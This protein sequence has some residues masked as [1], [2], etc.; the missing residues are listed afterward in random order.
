[1][2][3]PVGA[4]AIAMGE[5]FVAV[6]DDA[7]SLF[8]NPGGI[9]VA[10]APSVYTSHLFYFDQTSIDTLATTRPT[11]WGGV[12]AGTRWLTGPSLAK[13]KNN[14][15]IGEFTPLERTA[16][17]GL[18]LGKKQFGIGMTGRYY[19]SLIG[20]Q[21]A[22]ALMGDLGV[23]QTFQEGRYSWGLALQNIGS[24]FGFGS[25]N[26]SHSRT[27]RL[28]RIGAG[29]QPNNH[30]L[31]TVEHQ[32]PRCLQGETH[33]GFEFRLTPG[34]AVRSGYLYQP[35]QY[36][37]TSDTFDNWRF[38]TGMRIRN[39]HVDYAY[40]MTPSLGAS[41]HISLQ[42]R[43]LGLTELEQ[44][45]RLS[46]TANP[47]YFSPNQDKK[48][49]SVFFFLGTEG[50]KH[51]SKWRIDIRNRDGKRVRRIGGRG[52]VPGLIEWN[53]TDSTGRVVTARGYIVQARVW[54]EKYQAIS[55]PIRIVL[56]LTAP[57][58]KAKSDTN[59]ISPQSRTMVNQSHISLQAADNS[60]LSHWEAVVT[61]HNTPSNIVQKSSGPFKRN[62]A[63]FVWD[64][65]QYTKTKSAFINKT[66]VPNGLYDISLKAYDKAGNASPPHVIPVKVN[67][68]AELVLQE[69]INDLG[70]KEIPSGYSFILPSHKIFKTHRSRQ[71]VDGI[72]HLKI[73]ILRL[74][75][76]FPDHKI[77]IKAQTGSEKNAHKRSALASAQAWTLYNIL[78]KGGISAIRM[79]VQGKA[80]ALGTI[81]HIK[82]LLIAPKKGPIDI[83]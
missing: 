75:R 35:K 1:M 65:A 80:G 2:R 26:A 73:D 41:H 55:A 48:K 9:C 16:E 29:Y 45:G 67:V 47:A 63:H 53:G 39:L 14:A 24:P 72:D 42:F 10:R 68:Q 81:N 15:T 3:I 37:K 50:V 58:C 77:I 33:A 18:A 8:W 22:I 83:P 76:A 4:R 57:Q 66:I 61:A 25:D 82:I 28:W 43:F 44:S 54:G 49:D 13:I 17:F 21:K 78:L 52:A 51:I 62:K 31:L 11:L 27:A 40:A 7:Q 71:V 38:G 60:L 19:E 59:I 69:L 56:D 79:E 30:F 20:S 23:L 46:L 64:G 74:L 70:I 12:A 36:T 5:A 32:K 34:F 6:A